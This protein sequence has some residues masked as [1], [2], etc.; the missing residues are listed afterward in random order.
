MI[1]QN[2]Q[3]LVFTLLTAALII[4]INLYFR[5]LLP[6]DET[7][8]TSV[9]WEMWQSG[10]WLVPHINGATYDHKPPM[11]FWLI[12]IM[13]L[14]FGV[15]EAAARLIVPVLAC[16]NFFLIYQLAQRV[17]P[18]QAKAARYAPL[19]L[20]SFAGWTLYVPTSMFDLLITVFVLSFTNAIWRYAETGEKPFYI[21]AGLSIGIGILVKGPVMFVYTLPVL[22]LYPFWCRDGMIA[23]RNFARGSAMSVL[24]GVV[25]I[26]SW[27]IPA[28]ISGGPEYADAIFWRQSAGRMSESFSHAR[29]VYWY[30]LMLPVLILPWGLLF[31]AWQTRSGFRPV[32]ADRFCLSWF[33]TVFVIFSAMSGKQPHYLFPV[34]PALALFISARINLSKFDKEPLLA[35]LLIALAVAIF[36]APLW[37]ALVFESSDSPDLSTFFGFIPLLL[38]VI[39]MMP[40]W[41]A[42]H[43]LD[44]IL[45]A[46]PIGLYSIIPSL[47]DALF[48]VYDVKP[49][50]QEIKHRQDQGQPV[51]YLGKYHNTFQ[52]LGR[53]EQPLITINIAERSAWLVQHPE[54]LV[55]ASIR[56][57]DND[58]M[59]RS[60]FI[61]SYRGKYHV[62]IRGKYLA[63]WYLARE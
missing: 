24:I 36:T 57:L 7:R 41:F 28:A 11:M 38:A 13:W 17:Y 51:A 2:R 45:L 44:V 37:V 14:V 4:L 6:V 27:A 61:H 56:E 55:I 31:G 34:F 46:L 16:A 63:Q 42:S 54:H 32:K 62:M 10:N 39:V 5:P 19:V 18:E 47:S 59:V 30:L 29:P 3:P 20:L 49:L 12:N 48:Q 22:L 21:W 35:L 40:T 53:L 26:L 15:S 8:Y 23:G 33:I 50:A 43:R 60:E 9:A 58:L 52:F 1:N 25:I